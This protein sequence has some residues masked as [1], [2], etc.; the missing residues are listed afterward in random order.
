MDSL[1]MMTA[2]RSGNQQYLDFVKK[3]A[4][5]VENMTHLNAEHNPDE[6][7]ATFETT[8]G[9]AAVETL[10]RPEPQKYGKSQE[11]INLQDEV[12]KLRL[13]LSQTNYWTNGAQHGFINDAQT[14]HAVFYSFKDMM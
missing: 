12:W 6:L 10:L 1:Q 2:W 7:Y 3:I 14:K 11:L 4:D 8:V 9:T 5:A 13:R